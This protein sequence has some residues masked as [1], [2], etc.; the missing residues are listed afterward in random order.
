[1][2]VKFSFEAKKEFINSAKFYE[3]RI[4]GLGKRFK[5]VIRKNLTF[6]QNNPKLAELKYNDVRVMAIKT[7]PFT[8]H[9]KIEKE[10]IVIVAVFHTSQDPEK[11]G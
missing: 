10:Y 4:F 1:M 5:Q 3:S 9:H 2:K 8:I 6:I 7:F 11:L